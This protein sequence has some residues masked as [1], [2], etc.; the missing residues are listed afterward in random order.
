[1][2]RANLLVAGL[3]ALPLCAAEFASAWPEQVE[4]TWIGPEYW[5]NPLQDWRIADGRLEALVPGGNRNVNLLT[6]EL[7]A[8]PGG[9][10]MSVRLG[11]IRPREGRLSPGWAGFRVGIRGAIDDY[12]Y[13]VLRGRGL[14]A[15]VN[16][17]GRL[18]IGR[19]S[20]D[21]PPAVES[22]D[23]VELRLEARVEGAG[24]RLTLS[25]RDA[26]GRALGRVEAAV[27]ADRL[28]GNVA[29]V[30]D[31][32]TSA[33]RTQNAYSRQ[34]VRR[35]GNLRFWFRD[36]KISGPKLRR[37]PE[38]AFGPILWAQHTLSRGVLKMTA[39]M[40]PLG[41]GDEQAV[42]L[43]IRENGAWK[44][45]GDTQIDTLARTASF[46]IADWPVQNDVLYRLVYRLLRPDGSREPR[47]WTGT[48]RR[49]PTAKE[50]LVVAAFT[51][52][53]DTGF[54]NSDIVR[55]VG[56][57]DPDVLFFSGDQI[58]EDVAGYG[59]Q[60]L[61][62]ETAALDYL[63]KWYLLGWAFGDLMRDR[64]TVHMP[65]DHDVYQGNIW[66]AG[67][68]RRPLSEHE[69]GGYAM[70][71]EWVNAVQRTQTAH[72]PDPYDPRPI[73]QGIGVYFT[74][75]NY[76]RVSFAIVED[77]KFKSGPKGLVPPTGGRPDHVT[78]PDFDPR[79]YDAPG[80]K[81]L[82][83]RQLAFLRDW[84]ADWHSAV[85][86]VSLTQSIFANA[87]TTHGANKMRLVADLDSNG[88]PQSARNR[89]LA[90]LRKGFAFMIG[91]DQHLPSIIHHGIDEFGDAGYSFCVPSIAAGYPRAYEP[92]APARNRPPGAPAYAGERFDGLGNRMTIYAVA[93]PEKR[94]RKTPLELLHDKAS[95]YGL[96]RFNKKTRRITIECR[97]LL[98]DPSQPPQETQFA[99]WPR[100][101][102][103]TD[104]YGR[105]A[106]GYLPE[107]RVQGMRGPVVQVI[108]EANGEIVYTLR[109]AG[110]RF[111]PKIFRR[112]GAY[113][114]RVG[115]PETGRF[116]QRSGLSA[117]AAGKSTALTIR[118]AP[119]EGEA[120]EPR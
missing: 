25:A 89:A 11:R 63:R 115:E 2:R 92:D 73:E 57:D 109:I 81:L 80:A 68:R 39:Q 30:V 44:S 86:K 47:Y 17:D 1:M 21:A 50:T 71:P 28:I 45:L 72:L 22:F 64:V 5:A 62:V 12:R 117:D 61:P 77:R 74:E 105:K 90:E 114:V 113:T 75:L 53:K 79:A 54:P 29:L 103:Q 118:F 85:F 9:F 4:R 49:E 66:G 42:E 34:G 10:A 65:D 7:G 56:F 46:R 32:A 6:H 120:V 23:D 24:C 14:D 13:A 78:D 107:I 60:R 3:L 40:P 58:Y 99:G 119:A 55:N 35:K 110:D 91:G 94:Q 8:E 100:T 67:G 52:N 111:R 43:Q 26:R 59:I 16:T 76:G 84:A 48:V 96:V 87:A 83:A 69:R 38:R 41:R 33:E 101:I 15:G 27:E 51:G 108:D 37:R 20:A 88:W 36:W 31:S 104:N 116:Q 98:V 93:N 70:P 102:A 82:G 95:G 19:E 97:R 18:F 106:A 112:R